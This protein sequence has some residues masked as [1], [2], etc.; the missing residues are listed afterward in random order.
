MQ[1]GPDAAPAGRRRTLLLHSGGAGAPPGDITIPY[2]E[3]ADGG[4]LGFARGSKDAAT[5]KGQASQ[6]RRQGETERQKA[7][8]GAAK[9][10]RWRA[11]RRHTFA[12]RCD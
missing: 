1:V 11:E 8:P 7:R 6:S 3:L 12:R 9:T 4:P 10:L 5:Q 2:Q